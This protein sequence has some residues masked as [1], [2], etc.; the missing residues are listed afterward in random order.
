MRIPGADATNI[1]GRPLVAPVLP[2]PIPASG[3][4]LSFFADGLAPEAIACSR[5]TGPRPRTQARACCTKLCSAS[6]RLRPRL[7]LH[8]RRSNAL[9][10][11]SSQPTTGFRDRMATRSSAHSAS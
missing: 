1:I 2:D 7:L 9:S 3:P 5:G 6:S 4:H 8:A 10:Y 11:P